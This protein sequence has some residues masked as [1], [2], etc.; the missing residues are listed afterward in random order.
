[1]NQEK[2]MFIKYILFLF[3]CCTTLFSQ[4]VELITQKINIENA[5]RDKVNVTLSKLLEQSKYV[6]IVNARMDL[7]AFSL[8]N[9]DSENSNKASGYSPIPGL[10]PTVPQNIKQP[11]SNTYQYST[12][13]YLLYGLDILIY[14]ESAVATGGTQQNITE[15]INQSIPEIQDCDDCIRF[16][17]MNMGSGST[18]STYQEL[19]NNIE[20]LEEDKR[21][22]EQQ[23]SNW[24]FD[25]IEKQLAIAEDARTEW[26]NQ[27]RERDKSRQSADSVRLANLEKIEK[28]YRTKQDSLYLITSIKLDEAIRGRIESSSEITDKLIDIIKTGMDVNADKDLLGGLNDLDRN[29][30]SSSLMLVLIV[31]AVIFFL[32]LTLGFIIMSRNKQ[33]VYLKPKDKNSTK[34]NDASPIQTE[35]N[36]TPSSDSSL[37]FDTTHANENPDVTR[38]DLKSLRQ[39]TVAMGAQQS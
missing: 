29:Q 31:F 28:E 14:L 33:T 18:S 13:K 10:L 34:E 2:K 21:K 6:V 26:E 32:S 17:T 39:S 11:T 27:A 37:S 22:A 16:E 5:I 1:M 15:L 3:V 23:I 8:G 25:E 36:G 12:D 19:L 38:S 30:G 7:K 4:N 35:N 20:K 9:L 24:K